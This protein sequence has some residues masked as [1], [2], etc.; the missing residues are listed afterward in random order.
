MATVTVEKGAWRK[1]YNL[2]KKVDGASVRAG[3]LDGDLA[4]IAAVQEYGS[5]K[6]G[7]PARPAVR[8]AFENHRGELVALQAKIAQALVEG[9]MTEHRA[10]QLL[11][12]WAVGAIKATYTSEGK[13][14]PLAAA[15]IRAKGSSK[16]LI[17]TGQLV[18]AVTFVVVA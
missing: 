3:V 8:Q 1:L 15:T 14:T 11:G 18:A 2:L 7:I 4:V 5:P 6:R 12:M 9:K 13:F 10:M 17:D 16:P